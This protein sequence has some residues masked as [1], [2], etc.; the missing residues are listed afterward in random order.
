MLGDL[1]VLPVERQL[2]TKS[3]GAHRPRWDGKKDSHEG[4]SAQSVGRIVPSEWPES[5]AEVGSPHAS[6]W[7]VRDGFGRSE[8]LALGP[9]RCLTRR[10]LPES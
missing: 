7:K 8:A 9:L 6:Y 5:D 3:P 4:G 1:E 2:A 10:G